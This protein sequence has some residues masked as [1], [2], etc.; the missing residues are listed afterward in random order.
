MEGRHRW[1]R[2]GNWRGNEPEEGLG[3][4]LNLPLTAGDPR[5]WRKG[6]RG[7]GAPKPASLGSLGAGWGGSSGFFGIK[8]WR[9]LRA[10][11]AWLPGVL[12]GSRPEAAQEFSPFP[13]TMFDLNGSVGDQGW[14]GG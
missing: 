14:W 13:R 5:A 1:E 2:R 12:S 10:E 8:K 4:P 7:G 11:R 3:D 6:R 9:L